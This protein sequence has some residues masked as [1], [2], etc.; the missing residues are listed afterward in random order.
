MARDLSADEIFVDLLRVS[1]EDETI[2]RF[3]KAVVHLRP[4]DRKSLLN[5]F[6]QEMAMKGAPP[7]FIKAIAALRDENIVIKIHEW[8]NDAK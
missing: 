7:E 2:Y 6:I 3:I 5:S 1:R 4:F 8:M